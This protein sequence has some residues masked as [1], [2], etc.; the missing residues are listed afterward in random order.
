MERDATERLHEARAEIAD[1]IRDIKNE[2][3]N[4][5]EPRKTKDGWILGLSPSYDEVDRKLQ[6]A[7]SKEAEILADIEEVRCI[8]G[9]DLLEPLRRAVSEKSGAIQRAIARAEA[10]RRKAE[11]KHRGSSLADLAKLPEVVEAEEGLDLARSE[12]EADIEAL[13]GRISRVFAIIQKY[14]S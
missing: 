4:H 13:Q 10:T 9:G 6:A 2:S 8:C 5:I 14:E 7:I 12:N 11:I 1:E 3:L